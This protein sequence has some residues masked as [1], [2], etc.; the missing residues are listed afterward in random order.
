MTSRQHRPLITLALAL[1]A[2][3]V[4]APA[5][6][7]RPTDDPALPARVAS[8]QPSPTASTLPHGAAYSSTQVNT[9]STPGQVRVTPVASNPGFDWGDAGIGAGAA[10]ALTMIGLGGVLVLNNRRH[11]EERPATTA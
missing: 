3:A 7:A 8:S 5:A 10:F 4:L 2:V 11:R 9:P 1:I 6:S